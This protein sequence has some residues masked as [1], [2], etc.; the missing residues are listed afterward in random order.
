MDNTSSE[1]KVMAPTV[2]TVRNR[3]PL[4]YAEKPQG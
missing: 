3:D 1:E 2:M 4:V